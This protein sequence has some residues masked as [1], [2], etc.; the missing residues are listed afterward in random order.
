MDQQLSL[1]GESLLKLARQ[2]PLP[3]FVYSAARV[4]QKLQ[5]LHQ[6]LKGTGLPYRIYYAMKANRFAPLLTFM[7]TTGLVGI[8]VCSPNEISHALGCGFESGDLSFTAASLSE[9]DLTQILAYDDLAINCDSLS[10][11]RRIGEL[12]P[13]R[14]IG[15]RINPAMG[16]GYGNNQLLQYSGVKT[17]KFGIYQEQ[18]REVKTIRCPPSLRGTIWRCSISVAMPPP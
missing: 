15:L 14:R 6:V 11:I 5:Q 7:R 16:I 17:T 4:E 9:R 2:S 12:A 18:L 13:G 8:D 1:G 10:M 3:Q